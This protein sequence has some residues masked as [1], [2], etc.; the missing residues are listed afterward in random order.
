MNWVVIDKMS[1]FFIVI[2]KALSLVRNMWEY[3][4]SRIRR[5]YSLLSNSGVSLA[6]DLRIDEGVIISCT[7]L[8]VMSIGKNT[9]IS[10]LSEIIC[11]GGKI[12]I[13][14]NVY[15][16]KASILVSRDSIEIGDD[17][18]IAEYCVIRDQ[19]HSM[20]ARPIR[21]SGFKKSSIKIGKDCWLGAKVTVL[22][23]SVIGEGAVIGA[24]SLVRGEIPPYTLAVGCPAK[25]IKHLPRHE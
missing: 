10:N 23:G 22:R 24:H 1:V 6:K 4:L 16:G 15:I 17:A 2:R 20:Y 7:D 8:G 12:S 13:G 5:S 9:K 14:E 3:L 19:D 21:S 18:Q 11:R 25:V